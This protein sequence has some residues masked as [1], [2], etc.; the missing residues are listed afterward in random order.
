MENLDRK[1]LGESMA[2]AQ[3]GD[4]AAYARLLTQLVPILRR[5]VGARLRNSDVDDVVQDILLSVHTARSTFEPDRPFMPW[6]IT[7]ARRRIVDYQRQ[8]MRIAQLPIDEYSLLRGSSVPAQVED[9]IAVAKV[10]GDWLPRLPSSQRVAVELLKLRGLSL[11]EAAHESGLSVMAL[12]VA[13]HR[14]M[15]LLKEELMVG[16]IRTSQ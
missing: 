12:K 7:I 5:F 11:K 13:T 10:I 14:A 2:A 3:N 1:Q 9:E 4:A 15:K 8:T 6:L 16:S